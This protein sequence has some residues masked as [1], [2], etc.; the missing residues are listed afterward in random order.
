MFDSNWNESYR[1]VGVADDTVAGQQ[2]FQVV[3]EW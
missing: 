1:P 2:S 3:R